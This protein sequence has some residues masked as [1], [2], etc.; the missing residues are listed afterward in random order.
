MEYKSKFTGEQIDAL[1]ENTVLN[2]EASLFEA[3]V[4]NDTITLE[5]VNRIKD[6]LNKSNMQTFTFGGSMTSTIGITQ[7]G[8]LALIQFAI[9]DGIIMYS[10]EIFKDEGELMIYSDV[11]RYKLEEM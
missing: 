7:D 5:D 4:R 8:N 11:K 2:F 9:I 1:L 10:S 6:L 3:K